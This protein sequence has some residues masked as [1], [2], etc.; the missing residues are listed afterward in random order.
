MGRLEA[1][2]RE[3]NSQAFRDPNRDPSTKKLEAEAEAERPP[4]DPPVTGGVARGA[5]K[6]GVGWDECARQRREHWET[7]EGSAEHVVDLKARR[8]ANG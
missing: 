7:I 6:L 2:L 4:R 8:L 5:R 3:P 1:T